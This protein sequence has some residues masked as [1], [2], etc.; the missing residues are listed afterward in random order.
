MKK[1]HIFHYL[2]VLF[3]SVCIIQA[4][5]LYMLNKELIG[6]KLAILRKEKNV[7]K[8]NYKPSVILNEIKEIPY[9]KN[10]SDPEKQISNTPL[11][12][13]R[14]NGSILDSDR[15]AIKNLGDTAK[16]YVTS[17]LREHYTGIFTNYG[18][19]DEQQEDLL[20]HLG[21]IDSIYTEAGQYKIK[22]HE[23]RNLFDSKIRNIL[24]EEQYDEYL[25][26]EGSKYAN[27]EYDAILQYMQDNGMP[28]LEKEDVDIYK[29]LLKESGL[30]VATIQPGPYGGDPEVASGELEVIH[31]L[32]NKLYKI[33]QSSEQI[34]GRAKAMGM[35]NSAW[36]SLVDYYAEI[37]LKT[38][39]KVKLLEHRM[40][41]PEKHQQIM[42]A[43]EGDK[44]LLIKELEREIGIVQ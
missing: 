7:D 31:Q 24:T 18:L 10:N 35:S 22:L 11:A 38:E 16:N 25:D 9:T 4:I 30:Y 43:P 1:S 34:L 8:N 37:Y 28:T 27:S 13:K 23:S 14:E 3:F 5:A 36:D 20:D 12:A 2:S 17:N 33:E 44:E 40:Q 29:D 19:T 32:N 6:Y 39:N 41:F 42:N 15:L 26:S 21:N